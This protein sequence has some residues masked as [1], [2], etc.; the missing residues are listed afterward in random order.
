[1]LESTWLNA[2]ANTLRQQADRLLWCRTVED[3]RGVLCQLR[4]YC[5]DAAAEAGKRSG[6]RHAC[7]DSFVE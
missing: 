6:L 1:M 5:A 3:A 7:P 2:V 4:H